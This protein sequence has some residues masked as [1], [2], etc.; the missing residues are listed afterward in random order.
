MLRSH[1]G[2]VLPLGLTGN[3]NV[4]RD[5]TWIFAGRAGNDSFSDGQLFKDLGFT[6]ELFNDLHRFKGSLVSQQWHGVQVCSL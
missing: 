1:G 4:D 2:Y 3:G 6:T 5:I